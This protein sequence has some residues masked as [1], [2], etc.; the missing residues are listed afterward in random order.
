MAFWS[1]ET[2]KVRLRSENIISHND[3]SEFR[4]DCAAYTLRVGNEV[5]ISPSEHQTDANKATARR[6]AIGEMFPIPPGQFAFIITEETISVPKNAIGFI[7]MKSN[8]KLGG[9]INV[10][11]FHVDPGYTGKLIFAVFNAGP[12]PVQLKRWEEC[13]LLWLADLDDPNSRPEIP[14][15]KSAKSD[16]DGFTSIPARLV[17]RISGE[18]LSFEGLNAKILDFSKDYEMRIHSIEKQQTAI[19]T[20]GAV[21]ITLAVSGFAIPF[22]QQHFGGTASTAAAQ[23]T[24]GGSKSAN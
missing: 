20:L 11:G 16:K 19:W 18:M 8:V 22:V 1:G 7:S 15:S 12:R 4:V 9:L 5:Y 13:F 24:E 3:Y 17:N 6:L 14:Y 10:S 21:L 2:L 23:V